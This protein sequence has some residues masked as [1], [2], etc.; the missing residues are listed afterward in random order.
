MARRTWDSTD[1][2]DE[3]RNRPFTLYATN[4]VGDIKNAHHS[5]LCLL[6]MPGNDLSAAE[7]L[8][9]VITPQPRTTARELL[10][11]IAGTITL[12]DEHG[13]EDADV[14]QNL[15]NRV[16]A[17][18][19][20][21]GPEMTLQVAVLYGEKIARARE[22]T[23][24]TDQMLALVAA[25]I[26]DEGI[27][28]K[29]WRLAHTLDDLPVGPHARTEFALVGVDAR[30]QIDS[31]LPRPVHHMLDQWQGRDLWKLVQAVIQ[32]PEMVGCDAY[33]ARNGLV[34]LVLWRY[35]A[36]PRRAA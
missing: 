14:T 4:E 15:R 9:R 30:G 3:H 19:W 26:E 10:D 24:P 21:M 25:R 28:G 18:R 13:N 12:R 34:R 11:A 7:L 32:H 36:T 22:R 33:C 16:A 2:R 17:C 6:A 5:I 35:V 23:P 20:H 29:R 1:W 8:Q 27:A 31:C